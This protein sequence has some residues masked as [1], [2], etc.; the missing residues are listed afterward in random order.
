MKKQ[1]PQLLRDTTDLPSSI[2]T[3]NFDPVIPPLGICPIKIKHILV[4]RGIY[5]GS[6]SSETLKTTGMPTT[7]MWMMA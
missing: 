7:G 1:T 6:Y 3:F 5:E 2:K 4:P